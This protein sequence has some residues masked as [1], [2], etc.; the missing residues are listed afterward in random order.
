MRLYKYF[1]PDRVDVLERTQLRFSPPHA[2]NDPFDLKPNIQ[3]FSPR[4][5]WN[6]EFRDALPEIVQEQYA[7]LPEKIR[8][9]VS[10]EMVQALAS[11]KALAMEQEGFELA[12]F[13]A[14]YLRSVME[15]K[16]EE[17]VGIFCLTE[18]PDNLLMWAHYADS[19]QGFVVEFEGADRFFNQRRSKDDEFCHVRKVKY[20]DKRPTLSLSEIESLDTFLTKSLDW[21]YE[22]EWRMLMPLPMANRVIK[23]MPIDIHLFKFPRRMVKAVIL[24]SRANESLKRRITDIL[25]TSKE[26]DHVHIR[27]AQIDRE[28]FK[29]NIADIGS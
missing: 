1:H 17:L 22:Q 27:Q 14:P 29:V 15:T 26:Y 12:Q 4:E 9:L 11:A 5:Y 2:F 6:A 18:K 23:A 13:I 28:E 16:F 19:H 10:V 25:K 20:S 7:E 3:G 24:G 8:A 21:E